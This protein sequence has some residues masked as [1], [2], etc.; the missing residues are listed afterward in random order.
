MWCVLHFLEGKA[1]FVRS[2]GVL[3]VA[4]ADQDDNLDS[5]GSLLHGLVLSISLSCTGLH[6]CQE[7]DEERLK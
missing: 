1:F 3:S 4:E 5:S 6:A 2:R 7:A